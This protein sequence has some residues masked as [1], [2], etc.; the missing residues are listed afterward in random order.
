MLRAPL[1][2]RWLDILFAA[3]HDL[4]AELLSGRPVPVTDKHKT[5]KLPPI[6]PSEQRHD[7]LPV[8]RRRSIHDA[9]GLRATSGRRGPAGGGRGS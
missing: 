3:A 8:R 9:L 7:D 6:I 2:R 4:A 1:A 5:G